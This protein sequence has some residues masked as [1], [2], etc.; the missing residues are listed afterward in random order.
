MTRSCSSSTCDRPEYSRG[1]CELHYRRVL[2]T[3]DPR[4]DEPPR[5]QAGPR[6][7]S[8]LS[9]DRDAKTRGWCHAHYQRW[10][11]HGDVRADVPLSPDRGCAVDGCDRGHYARGWCSAHYR[12]W[13]KHG[14]PKPDE[15]LREVDGSGWVTH[16]YRGLRVPGH[17]LDLTNGEPA[18]T[19]H[20]LVMAQHLGR[21]LLPHEEVHHINGDR[22]DNRLENLELWST[23]QPRGQRVA[24]KVEHALDVLRT[25]APE[26]LAHPDENAGSTSQWLVLP[27]RS[28]DEI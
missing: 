23:S 10:R 14:D 28:P 9:C 8:V 16:G 11:A 24:D 21:A 3:G 27:E 15:P 20:R 17:L 4:S 7:C 19:E 25:Y 26:A 5:G 1:W 6:V 12:R 13:R 2:R 18:T 22:L